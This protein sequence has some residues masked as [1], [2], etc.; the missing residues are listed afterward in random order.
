MLR[1]SFRGIHAAGR[2]LASCSLTA[3]SRLRRGGRLRPC[4][5]APALR[6]YGGP[7]A[8]GHPWPLV[9]SS[10]RHPCLAVGLRP[11]FIVI[12]KPLHRFHALPP[13]AL[14]GPLRGE[15]PGDR[16]IC[17]VLPHRCEVAVSPTMTG[18][19]L[20]P[21]SFDTPHPAVKLRRNY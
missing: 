17:S 8:R 20:G 11:N 14:R 13:A 3:L 18:P 16:A 21:T 9:A 5:S 12:N 1:Q 4:S 7:P 15:R 19:I 10:A 6:A 2:A